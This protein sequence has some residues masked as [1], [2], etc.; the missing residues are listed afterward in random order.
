MTDMEADLNAQQQAETIIKH[1]SCELQWYQLL[2]IIRKAHL[3]VVTARFPDGPKTANALRRLREAQN[4]DTVQLLRTCIDPE[5]EYDIIVNARVSPQHLL[6]PDIHLLSDAPKKQFERTVQDLMPGIHDAFHGI[7]NRACLVIL[8][9]SDIPHLF[10]V[11]QDARLHRDTRK[12]ESAQELL[13]V[14]M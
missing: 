11:L 14:S 4:I 12:I 3:C 10:Q 5:A 2:T 9:K 1:V 6:S 7:L 13:K 8:N